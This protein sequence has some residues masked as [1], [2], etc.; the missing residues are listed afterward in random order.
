M[1]VHKR[2]QTEIYI[3]LI[4]SWIIYAFAQK[5]FFLPALAILVTLPSYF[6]LIISKE[7]N[8]G[9]KFK[10]SVR[11]IIN[12]S[13]LIGAIWRNFVPPPANSVAFVPIL[14]SAVQS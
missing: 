4:L 5:D 8:K 2:Q 12:I 11:N 10:M 1:I 7:K 9:S 3:P 6:L 14:V 13:V